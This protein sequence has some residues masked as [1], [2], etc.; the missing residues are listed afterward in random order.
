MTTVR[1]CHG[2]TDR[3]IA[4]I[5]GA[6]SAPSNVNFKFTSIIHIPALHELQAHRP[7][8]SRP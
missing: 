6:T 8:T 5:M 1:H 3:V 4:R 2:E 7:S